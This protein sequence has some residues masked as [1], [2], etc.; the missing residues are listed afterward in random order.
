MDG[1]NMNAL[2]G[3]TRPGDLASRDALE[4]AQKFSTPARRGGPGGRSGAMKKI[5]E[6]VPAGARPNGKR[7]RRWRWNRSS[8]SIGRVK[9]FAGNS[10][11]WFAALAYILAYGPGVRQAT[12]DAVLNANYIRKQLRAYTNC[13]YSL[14]SM[15]EV[16]FRRRHSKEKRRGAPWT[17]QSG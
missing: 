10:A 13:P 9:A 8:D 2:T 6:P 15:H 17:S 4:P 14:P 11:C 12:E 16:V 3:V 7:R 5:L 1:A